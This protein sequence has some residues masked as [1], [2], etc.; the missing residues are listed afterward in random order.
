[1]SS[2][3]L[4]EVCDWCL[5]HSVDLVVVGPEEPLTQGLTDL[6]TERG[7]CADLLTERGRCVDLLTE[8]G[9]CAHCGFDL[10]GSCWHLNQMKR[11]APCGEDR[12]DLWVSLLKLFAY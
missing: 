3:E 8:R 10:L 12:A 4:T 2:A 9:T 6:L 11:S 7:R 1:M 5:S